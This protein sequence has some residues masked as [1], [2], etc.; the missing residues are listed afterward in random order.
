MRMENLIRRN[1]PPS[2]SALHRSAFGLLGATTRDKKQRILALEEEQ[3]LS[4]DPEQCSKARQDL[5]SPR[6]RLAAELEWL[7]GLSPKRAFD[8]RDLVDKDLNAYFKLAVSENG[9]VRANLVAAGLEM[10]SED[11][12]ANDWAE[13]ILALVKATGDM[14][15]AAIMVVLNEDRA[16]AECPLIQSSEA[17]ESE[18]TTRG[19][20]FRDVIRA[21]LDRL[22]TAQMLKVVFKVV[23][24]ATESG[25]SRAPAL[26]DEL[27]D[28]YGL[29]ARAFLE[30]EADNVTKLVEA[31]KAVSQQPAELK[32]L[33]DKLEKVVANWT[34]VAKP[35]QM[36]MKA[37]GLVHDLSSQ[38]GYNIRG[39]VLELVREAGDIESAKRLTNVLREHFSQFPELAELVDNDVEQLDDMARRSSFIEMLAPIRSLCKEAAQAADG[40][41]AHA[42]SHG[43]RIISTAPRL[44]NAAERSGVTPDVIRGVKDEVAYAI[45]SCAVDYGNKTSKWQTCLTMLEAAN[46]FANGAEAL[47]R[48]QKNLEVVRRNV[49]LYGDLTPIDSAPSLYTI[50]GCGVTLYGNT[51]PDPDSGSYMATY[52]FVLVMIPIFPIC[53]YRVISTGGSSYRF[54][55]KGKLRTFDKWHI[56]IA[57]GAIL[58]MFLQK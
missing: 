52:Y 33:L 53:R 27:I 29:D 16:L 56:A 28:A 41:P 12:S 32:P 31:A 49:R 20:V 5:T 11:N 26:L 58:F 55:G 45:C 42:D 36:S 38:V 1:D 14:D 13:Q 23:D 9:L 10:L 46:I 37:R 15:A 19:R 34:Q 47:E 4:L 24:V 6:S 8:Y 48:V 54:L 18:L 2:Q 3:S 21:S 51:D 43:Q 25:E 7:P 39:L 17:V 50:N 30:K 44:I 40:D 57:V 22:A 35:I